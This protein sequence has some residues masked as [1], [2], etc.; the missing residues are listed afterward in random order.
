VA[1]NTTSSR[2]GDFLLALFNK[3]FGIGNIPVNKFGENE[4]VSA[5]AVEDIWDFGGTYVFPT[6]ATITHVKQTGDQPA[7]RTGTIYVEGLDENWR[8]T[9]QTVNLDPLDTS[10]GVAL[11]TPLVRI[12]RMKVHENVVGGP[13]ILAYDGNTTQVHAHIASGNNQTLM[14]IY[15]VPSGYTAYMSKYYAD[16]VEDAG[17]PNG[18]E[19]RLW[20]AD[21]YNNYEFQVKHMRGIIKGAGGFTQE[22]DPW[23]SISQMSDIKISAFPNTQ[24]GNVHAGFDLILVEN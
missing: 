16:V 8:L 4:T 1:R 23:F 6:G 18:T 19:I 17:P 9:A 13:V 21:R 22:F 14:A 12:F 3:D 5:G 20:T 15:T 10:S 7:L 2:Y 24:D 11:T